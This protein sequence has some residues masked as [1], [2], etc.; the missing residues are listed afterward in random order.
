MTE[1][2]RLS[3]I[4]ILIQQNKFTEAE[5][6][7]K[8]LLS[9]DSNDIH[10]LSLLAEVNLQQSRPDTAKSIIDNAIGLSPDS[11]HLFFIKSRIAIQQDDYD[12]AERNIEQSIALDP[13]DADYFALL[14]NIKLS[15]KQFEKA[16][17]LSDTALEIDAENLLA[18]NTRST[19][20]L[21]LNKSEESFDTI[22][23]ALREDP[24]NAYTHANYGWGLLEK[25]DPKQALV[26]FKESLKNDPDFD[27]AQAGMVEAL[28]ATNPFYRLFLK[29]A[30]WMSNLTARYQWGVIIG[31]Y[32]VYRIINSLARNN[33]ALQPYLYPLLIVLALF[34]FST[35]VI[36]PISNLFLRFNPYGQLLLDRKEKMSS[37]F[38]AASLS[39]SVL[40]V[41]LYFIFA[42]NRFLPIAAF[43]FAM[44]L[45]LSVMFSRTKQKNA[46]IKYAI[47]MTGIGILAIGITFKTGNIVNGASLIF[48]FG[49]IGFQWVA[50]YLMIKE[51]NH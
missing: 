30:F 16:L 10:L 22:R 7:L 42:D 32:V 17:E 27:T 49:F 23:G 19:A 6:I 51:S 46:L 15:R 50:N 2:S 44:M 38:V 31:F 11:P 34:A 13:Y 36:T 47:V 41:L 33:E 40:G 48:I 25:G 1:D 45:P 12:G 21:K 43:G 3:K 24:N 9:E 18:L 20:L 29:Y 39:V 14:A 4:G 26:H 28:K 8:E 37:N 35:W 5:R